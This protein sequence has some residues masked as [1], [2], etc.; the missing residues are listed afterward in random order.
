MTLLIIIVATLAITAFYY[1]SIIMQQT[2]VL[3]GAKEEQVTEK[4]NWI[5]AKLMFAFLIFII[6]FFIWQIAEY[7]HVILPE[8]ASEHGN[9]IDTLW[10][11]N[12]YIVIAVFVLTNAVLFLFASKYYYKKGNKAT[13]FAHS[14]KL[15]MIWTIIPAIVLSVIIIYGLRT[16]NHI[17]TPASKDALTIELYAKQFDW[18]AR[19]PG[20][21]GQLGKTNYR[22]ITDVNP[23]ALDE[24]DN[25]SMDDII[26]KGE[27]HIP[28][29]KEVNF[30]FRSRDVIHSAFMPHFRAQMNCVPGMETYFHFKPIITTAEMRK[31]LNKQDFDYV[32]LCNK[33]CGASHFNMQMNIIVESEA[34][35]K[36]WLAKQKSFGAK[37]ETPAANAASD[38]TKNIVALN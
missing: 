11:F 18:T 9:E 15:E 30:V 16:W 27:F 26:T 7:K 2:S 35:Y 36:A 14:T 1:L 4:D 32:L 10:D 17:T 3:K 34:D 31:K 23:L 13:F 12:M 28:V 29:G 5:N 19:Y 21:D 24:K 37:E 20:M 22:L 8:S 25:A 33:I 6:G 38:T